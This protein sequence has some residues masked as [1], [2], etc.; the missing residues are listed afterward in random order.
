MSM[1]GN[2]VTNLNLPTARN[3]IVLLATWGLWLAHGFSSDAVAAEDPCANVV[4]TLE[5]NNCMNER[6]AR[7]ERELNSTYQKVLA[8]FDEPDA[9]GRTQD[10]EKRSLEEAQRHWIKFRQANCY[11]IW[12]MNADGTIRVS[13]KVGC[14]EELAIQREQQL[15]K[16]FLDGAEEAEK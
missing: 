7:A 9:M 6:L 1:L 10:Q 2:K 15:R 12:L 5:I 8:Q 3:W 11:V 13:M 14:L 16:W 4:T